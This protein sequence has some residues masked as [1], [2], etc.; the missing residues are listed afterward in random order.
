[1]TSFYDPFCSLLR[2]L[3]Y[4]LPGLWLTKTFDRA[5]ESSARSSIL[6]QILTAPSIDRL[7][8]IRMVKESRA[9]DVENRL[10]GMA[11]SGQLRG[12]VDEDQLKQ[13][14]EAISR[15]EQQIGAGGA[16]GTGDG[17]SGGSGGAAAYKVV[18][19]GKDWGDDLDDE[20]D[21]LLGK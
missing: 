17:E 16:G 2:Y 10:I 15:Q 19:R 5:A 12:K 13:L 1:M 6:S 21:E 9:T 20:L 7:S 11:R 3:S 8:R 4:K 18:R 14:L